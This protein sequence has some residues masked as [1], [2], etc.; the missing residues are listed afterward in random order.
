MGPDGNFGVFNSLQC[1]RVIKSTLIILHVSMLDE[2]QKTQLNR[3]IH[4]WC[5]SA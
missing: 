1:M 3:D 2:F 5:F 4:F